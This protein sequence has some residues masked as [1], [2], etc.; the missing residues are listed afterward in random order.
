MTTLFISDLHLSEERPEASA[1]FTRFLASEAPQADALYILGDLFEFWIGDDVHDPHQREVLANLAML[2]SKGT[3]TY[4]M[5]GNRDFLTGRRFAHLTG[6]HMLP[7]GA[8]VSLYGHRTLL[9]HGDRL[10]TD[11]VE[12]QRYRRLF[13]NPVSRAML[14]ALPLQTRRRLATRARAKSTAEKQQKNP[15]IMDVNDGAV[16]EAMREHAA[17]TLIHG[18]THRPGIHEF[19]FDD[20]PA[21]RV[22]LGAWYDHGSVLRWTADG[23]ALAEIPFV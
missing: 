7:D 2:T 11:D 10:C 15:E 20:L 18:H 4:F 1:A 19:E 9:M 14:L 16:V 17:S 21:E 23:H 6:V 13:H 3:P 5:R 22:V 12:Y 8:V